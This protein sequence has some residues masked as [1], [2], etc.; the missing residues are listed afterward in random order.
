MVKL[1]LEREALLETFENDVQLLA[2]IIRVFLEDTPG[3]LANLRAAVIGRDSNQ[4]A[5]GSH[6]LRG[7]LSMFG[8]KAAVEA[9]QRLE[10]MGRQ[11]EVEFVDEA[12]SAFEREMSLVTSALDLISN[13]TF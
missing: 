2:E 3:R 5:N 9:V 13:N 6:S 12:F 4:I 1:V 8:A 11:R 7:S 10:Y